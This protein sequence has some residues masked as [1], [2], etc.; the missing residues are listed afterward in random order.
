LLDVV[1]ERDRQ[2]NSELEGLRLSNFRGIGRHSVETELLTRLYL[3]LGAESL[4]PDDPLHDFFVDR[5]EMGRELVR[6][7]LRR[8]RD[9]GRLRADIDVEQISQEVMAMILGLEFQW[10]ID[11]ESI[12]LGQSIE[13]YIDNLCSQLSS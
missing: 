10:M 6:A 5:F 2:G 12:D 9:D 3:V 7:I 8:E 13:K 1:A 4:D 11:P